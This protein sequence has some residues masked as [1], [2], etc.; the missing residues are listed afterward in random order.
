MTK[1]EADQ[2]IVQEY[3]V[4]AAPD[5]L[6][7]AVSITEYR[8]QWLPSGDLDGA[9]PLSLDEGRSVRYAMKEPEPPFRR[10]EVT[11]EIEPIGAGRSLFRITHRL[12]AGIEMRAANSNT[13]PG[14]RMAA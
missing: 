4:D 5:K 8:E 7:R 14:I 10:S 12:T 3:E 9:E 11:F 1:A 6:W 2:T 13:R